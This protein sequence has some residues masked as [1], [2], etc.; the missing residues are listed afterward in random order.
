LH[1]LCLRRRLL[2]SGVI[3]VLRRC[4]GLVVDRDAWLR[5]RRRTMVHDEPRAAR[6]GEIGPYPLKEDAHAHAGEGEELNVNKGPRQ[7]REVSAQ[8]EWTG[9]QDGKALADDGHVAFV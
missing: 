7:P 8:L 5:W 3:A 1:G 2:R 9:L 6:T 4:G